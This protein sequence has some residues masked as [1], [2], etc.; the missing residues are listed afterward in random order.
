[1]QLVDLEWAAGRLLRVY[2]EG[3]SGNT[4]IDDCERASHQ[5][6]H[7]LVVENIDYE[8]LEVSSPGLDRPLRKLN[9]FVRFVGSEAA[10]K[11]RAPFNGRKQF[12]GLIQS[13]TGEGSSEASIG[14]V[15]EGKDGTDQLLEFKLA[16]LDK[17][18]LVPKIDFRS[19]K[20]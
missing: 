12:H 8:R 15:F 14:L 10:V 1:M 5:L 20:R 7:V 18:H 2:I 11:L 17:A 3:P 6:S 9:D 16:E 19:N 13:V 4:T